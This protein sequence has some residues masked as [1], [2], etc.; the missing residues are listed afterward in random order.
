MASLKSSSTESRPGFFS[1]SRR[2][3][4]L[5]SSS[6]WYWDR[7]SPY[8][9]RSWQ[10]AWSR[11]ARRS[12]APALMRARSSGQK[13]TVCKI[14][15]SSPAVLSFTWFTK[16][17]RRPP[18]KSWASMRK[19]RP[20]LSAWAVTVPWSRWK[21]MSSR[22][23]RARWDRAPERKPMASKR[24]VL[25]WAFSPPDDVHPGV[26]LGGEVL[27]V[28]K[29]LQG[30]GADPHRTSS[31]CPWKDTR[32]PGR[33]F[34][35]R[36]VHI[37]PLTET[38]PL[39]DE[40]LGLPPRCPPALASFRRASSLMYSVVIAISCGSLMGK[41]SLAM[42]RG[43]RVVIGTPYRWVHRRLYPAG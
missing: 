29:A 10:M 6:L 11:K 42:G 2:M 37:A 33:S 13:R 36:M 1:Q 32:S 30:D 9:G 43:P 35:P 27:I 18:R 38:A 14:P 26:E 19:S 34:F 40:D 39:L 7:A 12:A 23:P 15:A 4:V 3:R 21:E 41:T 20:R 22:S 28:A 8:R 24:L 16:S 31:S 17:F 5:C 25:P